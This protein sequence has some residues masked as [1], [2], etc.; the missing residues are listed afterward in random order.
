MAE[1]KEP[2]RRRAALK[3]IKPG[4]DTRS[5]IYSLGVLLYELLTSRTPFDSK[6]LL[7][8]GLEEMRRTL[9]E[10]EPPRPSQRLSTLAGADLATA[11]KAR[12]S[13]A[14]KLV[15]QLR[16]DLDWIVMKC[17]EKERTRRY[18]TATG[19]ARDV[20]QFR[21]SEPITARPPSTL[22]TF[23]KLFRRHQRVFATAAAVV[24]G[25]IAGLIALSISYSRERSA[26]TDATRARQAETAARQAE[27]TA[28]EQAE[29]AA[30]TADAARIRAERSLYA[31]DMGLA[32]QALD[33]GHFGRV[34]ELVE[35]YETSA[36]ASMKTASSAAERRELPGQG[37]PPL[38]D[39]AML[40]P[41]GEP[42]STPNPRGWEWR[43]LRGQ[44]QNDELF[45]LTT[46]LDTVNR[47]AFS[48]DGRFLAASSHDNTVKVWD[49]ARRRLITNFVYRLDASTG[50]F[51]PDGRRMVS[52]GLDRT[53]H[54]HDTATWLEEYA[55]PVDEV[56][57]GVS[58]SPDSRS[59]A[60]L[61]GKGSIM[62]LDVETRRLLTILPLGVG[63]DII[64]PIA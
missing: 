43:F 64:S 54:V 33:E 36:D 7:Q 15:D 12:R 14:P 11:A 39:R 20:E 9:L 25:I 10:K 52:S 46:N 45:T 38:Q 32:F 5:D 42:P 28:R 48:P 8:S 56:V 53:I 57:L 60:L 6:Q 58:T 13:D 16:G 47:L 23:Q 26:R 21:N 19:L 17:L 3:V 59:V 30:R 61:T 50:S 37:K 55:L 29:A 51:S 27:T 22:Y 35:K 4:M 49:W 31:A 41:A 24:V 63:I 18:D 2:V 1:Q 40:G 62:L 44:T 34:R